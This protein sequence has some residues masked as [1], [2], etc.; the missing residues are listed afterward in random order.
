VLTHVQRVYE[1]IFQAVPKLFLGY[2]TG[3]PP[4]PVYHGSMNLLLRRFVELN[5]EQWVT[6]TFVPRLWTNEIAAFLLPILQTFMVLV[7]KTIF[8]V[9]QKA[10]WLLYFVIIHI[11]V[12]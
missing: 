10:A 6:W 2:F 3:L 7:A 12:T 4:K 1:L 5:F 11:I 8:I 9:F